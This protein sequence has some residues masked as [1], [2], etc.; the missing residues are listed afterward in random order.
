MSCFTPVKHYKALIQC[1]DF[2]R[3]LIILPR[4]LK[5]LAT[6]FRVVGFEVDVDY[7]SNNVLSLVGDVNIYQTFSRCYSRSSRESIIYQGIRQ[8]ECHLRTPHRLT[9]YQESEN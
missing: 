6:S 5:W 7:W 3:R 8:P 4:L 9:S 1:R 2:A